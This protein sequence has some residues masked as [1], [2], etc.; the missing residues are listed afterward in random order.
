T[1][2]GKLATL[3]V[4]ES[5]SEGVEET[6]SPGGHGKHL[7]HII[8][9]V[10]KSIFYADKASKVAGLPNMQ[11]AMALSKLPCRF[12][13]YPNY[14]K[15]NNDRA[16][17]YARQ[18]LANCP[19]DDMY[20]GAICRLNLGFYLT[21]DME[22]AENTREEGLSYLEEALGMERTPVNIRLKAASY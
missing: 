18:A 16:V 3:V 21:S 2:S 5:S 20:L 6:G 7:N 14:T 10:K 9:H 22:E 1:L 11:R 12:T 15:K 19:K 8:S 13:L 17:K 4:C